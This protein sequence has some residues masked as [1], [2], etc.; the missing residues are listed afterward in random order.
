MSGG[1]EHPDFP[2]GFQVGVATAAYQIE[3]AARQEGKGPSIW[4]TFTRVPGVVADAT[5]G[6]VAIDHYNRLEQD[7]DVL[8]ELGVGAYRFSIAWSRVLPEGRGAVNEAGLDFY[9]RLV[10]GLLE[11]GIRPAATMYHWDLPQALEDAGGWATR[12]TAFR[13][14]DYAHV[15]AEELGDRVETWMTL[16]EPWCAAFLG[17]ASG[18]MAPGRTDPV[19]ALR[20]MHHLNLAHGQAAATLRAVRGDTVSV[21][22]ALNIQV[23]RA[24]GD[25]AEVAHAQIDEIANQSFL[26]PMLRGEYP[27][28]LRERTAALTD[29]SFVADGDLQTIRQPL[30]FLGVNYY[31]TLRV[32]LWDGASPKQSADGHMPGASPWVG[33][34]GVE[35]LPQSAPHTAMGWNIAPE[36]LSG[37]LRSIGAE[38]PMLPLLVSENGAAFADVVEEDGGVDDADRIDYIARHLAVVA[39]CIDAG[40]D[41]RGYYL[42]T[43]IDNFE[44]GHGFVPKFGIMRVEEGTLR[45]IA[46]RSFG[47]YRD[48]ARAQRAIV[49]DARGG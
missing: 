36:A 7:L 6:D 4:D 9:R 38:F 14:A 23:P 41:V 27:P 31:S 32:R 11:R 8:A 24:E 25:H 35:F 37:V 48:F 45:R 26:G 49:C 10:D 46:K 17:Y 40:I 39:E 1:R 42:W 29:W 22:V 28:G 19:A 5:N 3:G 18:V 34:E 43:W 47:W 2:P 12:D 15:L 33:A 30:D 21:G 44:W 20:A 16:N 13:F